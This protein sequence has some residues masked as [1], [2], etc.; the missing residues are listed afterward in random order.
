M[1]N[2]KICPKCNSTDIYVTE[3][4]IAG[5]FKNVILCSFLSAVP[6]DRYICGTCGYVEHWVDKK[7]LNEIKKSKEVKKI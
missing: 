6:V 7:H 1:K 4:M 2:T 3:G 5:E